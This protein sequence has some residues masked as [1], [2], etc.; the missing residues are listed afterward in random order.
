VEL[1]AGAGFA[2]AQR[3]FGAAAR[4]LRLICHGS[5]VPVRRPFG[6][7]HRRGREALDTRSCQRP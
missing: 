4:L 3:V 2:C 1:K 6:E 7:S 5:I